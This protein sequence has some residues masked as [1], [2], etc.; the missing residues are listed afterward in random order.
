MCGL[1]QLHDRLT[2]LRH[3]GTLLG[4]GRTDLGH[5]VRHAADAVDNLV[6]G[7]AGLVHLA[8]A[9]FHTRDAVRDQLLDLLGGFGTALRQV[10]HLAG[11]H[12]KTATLF[13]RA[14]C[15]HRRVQGQD[16]GLEGDAVDDI[17][18]L[19]NLT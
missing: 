14:R 10:A 3:P 2:H 9:L 16:V 11:H 5:D 12:G 19:G 1:V 18:D 4:R 13:T 17:D 7:G 8:R 15:F 6:H